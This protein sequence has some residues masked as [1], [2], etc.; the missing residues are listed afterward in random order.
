MEKNGR[1]RNLIEIYNV[2]F[3][4]IILPV[5][6]EMIK[7]KFFLIG[8]VIILITEKLFSFISKKNY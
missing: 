2:V 8:Q 7:E 6:K 3:L 5:V 1:K 4:T